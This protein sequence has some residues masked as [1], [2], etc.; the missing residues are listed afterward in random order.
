MTTYFTKNPRGSTSPYDLFDNAQNFDIAVNSI[1]EVIW[2]DRFGNDRKTYWGMERLFSAQLLSQEQRFNLFIQ[3]SGYKVIGDY[4]EGPLTITE[5]NQLIRYDGELWK[6]TAATDIPF[7]TTGNDSTSWVNDSTHFVSIGDAVL[8]QN[9]ASSQDDL[10]DALINVKQP[11]PN[12][13]P[14]TQ[15]D[16]NKFQ[17][18]AINYGADPTF[19]LDSADALQNALN[20]AASEGFSQVILPAG[21]FRIS[22]AITIP[23]G[24]QL[25][26]QGIDDWYTYTPD[27]ASLPKSWSKGSHLVFVG[28]GAKAKTF[29]NISNERPAKTVNGVVCNFTKFT[30]EDSV[31]TTSATLKSFSVAVTATHA[32]QI[33]N[34]RIM[35]SNDG[36]NGYN[37]GSASLGDDWDIGLHIFS[38]L[39]AKISNVQVCGYWRVA[40]TL[41]TENDGSLTA[42]GNP[43]RMHFNK[44]FTQGVRGL[45]IRNCPQIDVVSNTTNSVTFKHVPSMRI[46][47]GNNFKISGSAALFTFTGS[48]SDG[49]NITLTGVTPALPAS[50]GVIRYPSAGNNLS[51][52][53]FEN[54]YAGSFD[55]ATGQASEALGLPVSF[56]LEIDGFPLRNPKFQNFKAQTIYDK[57][58]ALIGDTRDAKFV[59]SE[60]ENG[61]LVA[62]DISE[63]QG[64]TGNLRLINTDIQ[65]SVDITGFNPRD[66]FVDYRQFPTQQTNGDF[67]IQNWRPRHIRIRWSTGQDHRFMRETAGSS[68]LGG[69]SDYTLDGTQI[70][71]VNG[72]TK[73][74]L[75]TANNGG[76]NFTDG[77]SVISWFGSSGTVTFKGIISPMVDNSKSNGTASLRWT[78]VYAANGTINTSDGREKSDPVII[79]DAILDAWGDVSIIAFQWLNMIAEKGSDARW[80]FG[81]IAQQVRDAFAAHG[82]DGTKFGLLCYDEWDDVYEPEVEMREVI[83]REEVSEGNFVERVIQEQYET[84]SMRLVIPA[85]NRWGIRPDQCAWLEAAY[86]RRRSDRVEARL[87]ALENR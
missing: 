41:I 4:T 56:A 63:T 36:I 83:Y 42:L 10:G 39:D 2:K 69:W 59:N 15:H 66:C 30:N 72:Q 8:R 22:K 24:V 57:G 27:T 3:N 13:V 29:A 11:Y 68:G 51:G 26:G 38:G 1:T 48:T 85:G 60:F 18:S 14:V 45:L 47:A 28:S 12:A 33:S 53:N 84:N 16:Q 74:V 71:D 35:L 81:V 55:H 77:S 76:I 44:F 54:T 32:S 31:G 20:D 6:L 62:Y 78:Q 86:Q 9:L 37:N 61:R 73:N 25:V 34:L 75:L 65:S 21:R 82:I 5:Y 80:H 87:L 17:V 79:S 43:E 40:G 70:F 46:T 7:T 49:T 67:F 52:T 19:V 64:Y 50:M 58:C 23:A